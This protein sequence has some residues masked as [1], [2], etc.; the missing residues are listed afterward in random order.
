VRSPD[1]SPDPAAGGGLALARRL[2]KRLAG[3]LD[4]IVLKALQKDPRDR[5]SSV[6][7]LAEDLRRYRRQLPIQA[8]PPSFRYRLRK[9]AARHRALLLVA[10]AV[11]LLI[12]AFLIALVGQIRRAD[13]EA[14]RAALEAERAERE[15]RS[16]AEVADFLVGVFQVFDPTAGQGGNVTA[17]E[18]LDRSVERAQSD[19]ATQ[20]ASLARILQHIGVAY[21]QLGIYDAATEVFEKSLTIRART[22]GERSPEVSESLR[23]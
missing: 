11:G 15:A 13:G 9:A 4:A 5:Y 8:R 3:D 22:F 7:Q 6:D 10:G 2:Q 14:A 17:R 21:R 1:G 19:L 20:P 12:V 16:A 18:L 23:Y